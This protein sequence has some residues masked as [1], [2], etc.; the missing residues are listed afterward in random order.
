MLNMK[1]VYI[2][3]DMFDDIS[4]F[5]KST[6]TQD[7]IIAH[8]C[9]AQGKMGKGYA[10][11][12]RK[13][14]DDSYLAYSEVCAGNKREILGLK[15]LDIEDKH[16]LNYPKPIKHTPPVNPDYAD[17]LMGKVLLSLEYR[18]IMTASCIT[19]KYYGNN[20]SVVYVDYSAYYRAL[21][22]IARISCQ[23]R[24]PIWMT[25]IGTGLAN[26]DP[27]LLHHILQCVID[28]EKPYLVRVYQKKDPNF[29]K[30]DSDGH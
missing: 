29:L 9:N 14:F 10:L 16:L 28:E 2:N 22:C 24:I 17:T 25:D 4:S 20:K 8:G 11:G 3:K 21:K 19:Q 7:I 13:Y 12:F 26:G 30:D 27:V 6:V 23:S 18:G 15:I 1:P 5:L